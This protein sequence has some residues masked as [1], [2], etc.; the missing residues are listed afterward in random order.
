MA[1]GVAS[2]NAGYSSSGNPGSSGSTASSSEDGYSASDLRRKYMDFLQSK[3][4]ELQEQ[5]IHRHYYHGD[6][7]TKDQL[8]T[9]QLRGQPATIRDKI[10]RKIDGIV[11]LLERMK[12]DPKAYARTPKHEPGAE[13]ATG[14]IRYT[15]D[16]NNWASVAAE[17]ARDGAINGIY[18]VEFDLEGQEKGDPDISFVEIDNE[19]FFY[20]PT[21]VAFDFSDARYLGS[22]KWMDAEVVKEM[23]PDKD[24]EIDSLVSRA[25]DAGGWQHRDKE[26]KWVDTVS[27]RL[28][29]I[30]MWC[31]KKGKWVGHWFCGDTVLMTAPSP[32]FDEDGKS[33]HRYVVASVNIDHDGDRYGYIRKLKPLIDELNALVSKRQHLI[34]TRRIKAEKGAVDDVDNA[35]REAVRADGYLEINPGKTLN[36]DD[37]RTMADINAINLAIEEVTTAIEN[38]GPNVAVLGQALENSS[39][40]AIALLQQAGVAELGPG[41]ISNKDWKVRVYRMI[42][43]TQRRYW[44]AERW[45][46]VTDD[47]GAPKFMGLNVMGVDDLGQPI[48]VSVGPDGNVMAQG[49]VDELDVD[50]ILDEGPDTLNVMQ[51]TNDLL[52]M[53]GQSGVPIPPD[54]AIMASGLPA[55]EKKKLLDRLEASQKPDPAAEAAKQLEVQGMAADVDKTRAETAKIMGEAGA[56]RTETAMMG[57]NGGPPMDGAP[58]G[59]PGAPVAPPD[60]LNEARA[61]QARAA[62]MK[63]TVEA[64]IKLQEAKNVQRATQ[65]DTAVSDAVTRIAATVEAQGK[66][67]ADLT[68]AI[69]QMAAVLAAP[70]RIVTD[71]QGKP[72]GVE[73]VT[74]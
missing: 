73:T 47:E 50:I 53:L 17:E 60:P 45:I 16:T 54:I 55:S 39:G 58:A 36:F 40:R 72:V 71:A 9:L 7:L 20:D 57:H 8:T 33:V 37:A 28:F 67:Q 35:R 4:S 2:S 5:R 66:A 51:D 19:A 29:M 74:G 24:D 3:D 62:A 10:S 14:A 18:G 44:T 11:G 30:E 43:N 69:A 41:I 34:H 63:D 70:K 12:Q 65:M 26:L 6:Q 56:V 13:V 59:M 38:F 48:L 21:S 22:A 68:A 64:S 49:G 27:K 15:C 52:T 46:R 23:I 1:L 32:F 42:W 25:P 31:R 61:M